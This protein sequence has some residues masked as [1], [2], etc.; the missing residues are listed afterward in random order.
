MP[1]RQLPIDSGAQG[2]RIVSDKHKRQRDARVPS[3]EDVLD[4]PGGGGADEAL[5]LQRTAV[6]GCLV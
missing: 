5:F 2:I 3:V 6:G 4:G 1:R